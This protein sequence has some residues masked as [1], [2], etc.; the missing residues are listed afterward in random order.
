MINLFRKKSTQET[1]QDISCIPEKSK[2]AKREYSFLLEFRCR[3]QL[4]ATLESGSIENGI[5]RIGKNAQCDL[6]IPENDRICAENHLELHF[7]STTLRLQAVFG[8]YFYSNS[9]K[10]T[11]ASLKLYDR[12]SFGDCELNVK[13]GT[14]NEDVSVQRHRLEFTNGEKKGEFVFLVGHSGAG[15]SSIIRMLLCEERPTSGTVMVNGFNIGRYWEK[16]P[17]K[18]LYVPAS[19]LKEGENEIVIFEADGLKGDPV[20]EFKD[21]PTLE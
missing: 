3:G 19:L 15:K 16:G 1:G 21:F 10:N 4:F 7:S 14:D 13:E 11:A 20:V 8:N 17:Q 9:R 2:K 6:V 5:F 18:S 12:I